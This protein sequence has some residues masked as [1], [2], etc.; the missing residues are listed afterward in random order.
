M[1]ARARTPTPTHAHA[2][3]TRAR[4][5]TQATRLQPEA[6]LPTAL[7]AGAR[8]L[9]IMSLIKLGAGWSATFGTGGWPISWDSCVYLYLYRSYAC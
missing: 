1:G 6:G 3:N 8:G 7:L 9:V 2:P 5:R 4:A